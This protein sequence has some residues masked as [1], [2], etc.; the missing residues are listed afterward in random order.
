LGFD[1]H[2]ERK[3]SN[4][5]P[6]KKNWIASSLRFSQRRKEFNAFHSSARLKVK[7]MQTEMPKK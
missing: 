7:A 5:E 4:P 6:Q 2:C 3:R 1:C